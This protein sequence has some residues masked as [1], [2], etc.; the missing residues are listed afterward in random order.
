MYVWGDGAIYRGQWQNSM[1]HGCGVKISKQPNGGCA[2]S[3][4][5]GSPCLAARRRPSS[6]PQWY[7]APSLLSPAP[8]AP[9]RRQVHCGGGAVCER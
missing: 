9:T 8:R 4:A 5:P 6:W 1:M 7:A 3:T 2:R